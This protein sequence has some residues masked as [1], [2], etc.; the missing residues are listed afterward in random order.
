MTNT[1]DFFPHG[2]GRHYW[3]TFFYVISFL[4]FFFIFY[5]F[6][7]SIE[8]GKKVGLLKQ[9]KDKIVEFFNTFFES[10]RSVS[11]REFENGFSHGV[12]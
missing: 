9:E 3:Y 1:N 11:T 2:E 12:V 4:L 8:V 5:V 10:L 6:H 7:F